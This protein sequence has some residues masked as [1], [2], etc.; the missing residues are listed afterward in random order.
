MTDDGLK[1]RLIGAVVLLALGVIFLPV[2]FDRDRIEPID[3]ETLIP[4]AP[5]VVTVDI[6]APA[7][8]EVKDPAPH[9]KTMY[10]PDESQVA[11]PEPEPAFA[12]TGEAKAWVLQVASFR[13]DKHAKALHDQLAEQGYDAYMRKT[14]MKT[15]SITRV[16]VGPKFK[17]EPLLEAKAMIDKKFEVEAML[18]EYKAG[19]KE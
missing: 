7:E 2:L 12:P 17:K 18:L 9:P 6:P 4:E 15:G 13:F 8:P 10:V 14:P 11:S 5:E 1:Q 16:Y 19:N 3:Q